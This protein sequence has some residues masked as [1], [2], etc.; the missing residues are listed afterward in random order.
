MAY[1]VL[2]NNTSGQSIVD[3]RTD[4]LNVVVSSAAVTCLATTTTVVSGTRYANAIGNGN[5]TPFGA[6]N[7]NIDTIWIAT[8]SGTLTSGRVSPL[9]IQS[10][11]GITSTTTSSSGIIVTNGPASNAAK[12]YNTF[13]PDNS[14]VL[15]NNI[16]LANYVGTQNQII[17]FIAVRY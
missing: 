1:G 16:A 10:A 14:V 12:L 9:N 17:Q 8:S 13:M 2:I 15:N 7:N 11:P 6:P 4:K 3:T 5:Y